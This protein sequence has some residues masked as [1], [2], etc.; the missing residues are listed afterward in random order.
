MRF[1][2]RFRRLAALIATG[3]VVGCAVDN[4][5]TAPTALQDGR[6]REGRDGPGASDGRDGRDG[7]GNSDGRDGRDGPGNNDGRDGRDGPGNNDGREDRDG[8]GDPREPHHG[9]A[10]RCAQLRFE[11]DS[12]L[13]GPAGGFV[14]MGPATLVIPPLALTEPVWIKGVAPSDTINAV[15]FEPAGLV[16]NVPA[17]LVVSYVHCKHIT[18]PLTVMYTT[19]D[20]RV[21]A[22]QPTFDNISQHVVTA[23]IDH[24]SQ[25]AVGW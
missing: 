16:F 15:R 6:G 5:P 18:T 7:P 9:R 10:L 4:N 8:P 12:A 3:L 17:S 13:I 20:L 25:Y 24:F 11:S 21:L 23:R 2:M 1:S 19:D 22:Y 14:H